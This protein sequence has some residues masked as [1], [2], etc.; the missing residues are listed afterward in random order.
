M[1]TM[2]FDVVTLTLKVDLLYK[3]MTWTMT[4]ESEGLL[5]VAI[6][7]WLPLASYVVYVVF[8][9]TLVSFTFAMSYEPCAECNKSPGPTGHQVKILRGPT[10]IC[11]LSVQMSDILVFTV[12]L[13][14][15]EVSFFPCQ[16]CVAIEKESGR[17]KLNINK[18]K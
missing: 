4:F 6:Y 13:A 2:I 18:V 12:Y 17:K 8:L 9:T 11:T 10:E 7:I 15:K 3:K 1:S 14:L 5:I 16:K